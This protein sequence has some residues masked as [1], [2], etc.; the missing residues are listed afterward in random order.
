MKLDLNK[1]KLF[2]IGTGIFALCAVWQ[3]I[4]G[5]W[6]GG[7]GIFSILAYGMLIAAILPA[8]GLVSIN[9]SLQDYSSK[10]MLVTIGASFILAQANVS[11]AGRDLA[12]IYSTS[13]SVVDKLGGIDAIEPVAELEMIKSLEG[14]IGDEVVDDDRKEKL[15]EAVEK[16]E[17][18]VGDEDF[19]KKAK[20]QA[21]RLV[22]LPGAALKALIEFPRNLIA[23]T[24][25]M[26]PLAA[27][28]LA[29]FLMF[30]GAPKE[31]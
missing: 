18:K 31:E 27:M 21:K 8:V 7:L 13:Y 22:P 9:V 20:K 4:C 1:P 24:S 29:S 12:S 19:Q 3:L 11:S 15:E 23:L 28:I 25:L 14:V 16:L 10:L 5:V 30:L 2:L 17:E 6:F 26:F